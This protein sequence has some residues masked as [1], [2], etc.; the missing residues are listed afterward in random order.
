MRRISYF[1]A[2]FQPDIGAAKIAEIEA[3]LAAIRA[4]QEGRPDR[5]RI[6]R[7]FPTIA[8]TSR[9]NRWELTG[10]ALWALVAAR[11]G[12]FSAPPQPDIGLA[13]MYHNRG[14]HS[15]D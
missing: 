1:R 13:K 15:R 4:R 3:S 12:L 11:D 9:T 6:G 2:H 5:R 14:T 10:P 8:R 7:D